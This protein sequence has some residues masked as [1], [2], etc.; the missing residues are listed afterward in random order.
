MNGKTTKLT[1]A[2]KKLEENKNNTFDKDGVAAELA[3]MGAEN[4]ES[5][6]YRV[7]VRI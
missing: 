3:K 4:L 2:T 7:I 5:C 6:V 1:K